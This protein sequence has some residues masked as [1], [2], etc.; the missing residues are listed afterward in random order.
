MVV[1]ASES[2]AI[3]PDVTDASVGASLAPVTFMV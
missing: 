1:E 3:E 2:S